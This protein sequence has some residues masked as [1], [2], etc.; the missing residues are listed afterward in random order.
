MLGDAGASPRRAVPPRRA[1]RGRAGAACDDA[2]AAARD[3]K[4]WLTEARPAC[5]GTGARRAAP[6]GT[7]VE[8]GSYHGRSTIVLG[9]AAAEGVEVVAIDPH[10]GND[11][12]P[13]QIRG[14][15]RE[16]TPTTP[17]FLANLERGGVA[18][19]CTTCAGP[20]RRR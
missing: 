17:T 16:A 7:V 3:V 13:Q 1:E 20:R 2:L 14:R 10:A 18:D 6:A 9:R 5:C 11:R 19:P 8:I 15:R 12:G 4:G